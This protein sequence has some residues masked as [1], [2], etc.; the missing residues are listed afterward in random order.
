MS[1]RGYLPAEEGR[2]TADDPAAG[3][4]RARGSLPHSCHPAVPGTRHGCSGCTSA[5][6]PVPNSPAVASRRPEEVSEAR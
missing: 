1:L 5:H 3:G 4:D 2:P 6:L